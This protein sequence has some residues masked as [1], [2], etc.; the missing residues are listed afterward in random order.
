M[1]AENKIDNAIELLQKIKEAD[2]ATILFTKKDGSDRLM[3]CTLNFNRIPANKR[4]KGVN[5]EGILKMIKL[6]VLRVFDTEKQEWR[7][8]PVDGAHFIIVKGKRYEIMLGGKKK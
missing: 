1:P 2:I 4:P 5:L 8:I 3:K 7:S 6:N